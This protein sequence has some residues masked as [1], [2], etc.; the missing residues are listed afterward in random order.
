MYEI[1]FA[2]KY[3]TRQK[4]SQVTKYYKR[5]CVSNCL[6]LCTLKAK[7]LTY[8]TN[9]VPSNRQTVE[10]FIVAWASVEVA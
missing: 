3:L 8:L 2:K 6:D 10:G 5:P 1:N 4:S 7:K 9:C